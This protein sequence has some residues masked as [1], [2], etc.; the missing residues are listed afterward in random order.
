M[1]PLI[2]PLGRRNLGQS[3]PC[4]LPKLCESSPLLTTPRL[5]PLQGLFVTMQGIPTLGLAPSAA[6]YPA[7]SRAKILVKILV[8]IADGLIPIRQL[9]LCILLLGQ[10][11]PTDIG[12]VLLAHETP[13][14]GL[15]RSTIPHSST[16]PGPL[17]HIRQEATTKAN[18]LRHIRPRDGNPRREGSNLSWD[19]AV[20]TLGQVTSMEAISTSRL[21]SP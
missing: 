9:G 19:Q 18:S 17:G 4:Q 11:R 2:S 21:A 8:R 14:S 5:S 3:D 20:H 16:S 1:F 6:R 15:L 10:A 13:R 7:A 12:S